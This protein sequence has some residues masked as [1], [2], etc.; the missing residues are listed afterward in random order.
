MDKRENE[1]Q[2]DYENENENTECVYETIERENQETQIV[3]IE[4]KSESLEHRIKISNKMRE[5][6]RREPKYEPYFL[7]MLEDPTTSARNQITLSEIKDQNLEK[8]QGL[9]QEQAQYYLCKYKKTDDSRS[10]QSYIM[11]NPELLAMTD[12]H[13]VLLEAVCE[14]YKNTQITNLTITPETIQVTKIG[15]PLI[16]NYSHAFDTIPSEWVE[17]DES[18]C[19]ELHILYYLG[20]HKAEAEDETET[21]IEDWKTKSFT[22]TDLDEIYGK[23]KEDQ[24]PP[25]ERVKE[26]YVNKTYEEVYEIATK[27]AESWDTYSL[28]YMF[29]KM[30]TSHTD[31]ALIQKYKDVLKEFLGKLPNERLID[32]AR[33]N[34]FERIVEPNE[35]I[36]TNSF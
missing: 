17:P 2:Y 10:I 19:L 11:E 21:T 9:D 5:F 12:L 31:N 16:T 25:K 20:K 3:K 1:Y 15:T 30:D 26:D 32:N 29:W 34:I 13:N 22:E 4:K 23:L 35:T 7:Y 18:K 14:L 27:T 24:H 36:Q 28:T 8:C 33:K 6:F